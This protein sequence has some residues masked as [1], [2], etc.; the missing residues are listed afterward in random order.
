MLV[1]NSF[2]F[3][4][5]ILQCPLLMRDAVSELAWLATMCQLKGHLYSGRTAML[6][7]QLQR[8]F[9]S[10]AQDSKIFENHLNPVML[11]FIG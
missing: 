8:F 6:T 2:H 11:V 9:S 7:L 3:Y 10:K 4:S 1:V 5:S